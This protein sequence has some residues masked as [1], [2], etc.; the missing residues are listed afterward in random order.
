MSYPV[1]VKMRPGLT[2]LGGKLYAMGGCLIPVPDG[3][4][5]E[6]LH[7]YVIYDPEAEARHE[8]KDRWVVEGSNGNKYTI[9]KTAGKLRCTCPG[10][11]FRKKCKHTKALMEAE[12]AQ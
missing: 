3:T 4:T 5:L 11:G 1:K 7:E 8:I 9:T 10:Y 2:R 6:N 12:N